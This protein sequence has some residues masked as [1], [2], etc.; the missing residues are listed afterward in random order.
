MNYK[1]LTI[2]SGELLNVVS[3]LS[4]MLTAGIPILS[5]V[6]SL[7]EEARGNSK[8]ILQEIYG[9]LLKGKH[10]YESLAKFPMVFDSVTVNMVRASEE[11]GT[12]DQILKDLKEQIKK[13]IAL[14]RKIRSALTYPVLVVFVFMGVLLLI[15]TVVMPKI[16]TVFGQL[17]VPLPLPTKIL[18]FS[19]NILIHQTIF[20][21]LGVAIIG[22][23]GYLYF[24][25]QKQK[26]MKVLYMLPGISQLVR[27]LDLIRFTRSI[28]LLLNAGTSIT[29]ALDLAVHIVKKPEIA[30]AIEHARQTILTGKPMSHSF[31][32]HRKIFPG[33][34]I[35]LTQA[36]EKTGTLE[37]SMKDITEYMDYKV[38]D[39]LSMLT[40]LLEPVMLVVVAILVGSM[41]VAI[42]GPIYGL[43]GQIGPH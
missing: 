7:G 41:M 5:A 25:F 1:R 15:L 20:V 39:N 17:K 26:V 33:T 37:K 23:G 32:L 43:I 36:G 16:S 38:T 30:R 34:M 18:I 40:A 19:S 11:S 22:V 29:T 21:I 35:E 14:N 31:K 12:L 13:D 4:T 9:D 3:N 42:I 28:H 24:K 27:D 8:K 2:S 6:H 10:L